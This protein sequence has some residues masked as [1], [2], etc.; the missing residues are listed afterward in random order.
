MRQK[1]KWRYYCDHC[2]KVGGRKSSMATHEAHCTNNPNR[3]CRVHGM[4][5]LGDAPPVAELVTELNA[6]GYRALRAL[7][8][9]CPACILA[10][11]RQST[12]PEMSQSHIWSP[13]D[14]WDGLPEFDFRK[15]M[16]AVMD[17]LHAERRDEMAAMYG[18]GY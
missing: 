5:D 3:A 8:Q 4:L 16:K 12:W 13:R 6:K 2:K 11:M 18:G 15:E 1:K 10:A 14:I 17:E 7:A 9:D